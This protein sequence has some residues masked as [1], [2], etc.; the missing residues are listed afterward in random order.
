M[1][2]ILPMRGRIRSASAGA[3]YSTSNLVTTLFGSS[4][5]G[6][7][8]DA[9][10]AD[11]LYQ[12][13]A[14]WGLTAASS[15][16]D[17]VGIWMDVRN[18]GGD[19]FA[20]VMAAASDIQ[21]GY[22]ASAWTAGS[23]TVIDDDSAVKITYAGDFS[24]TLS[25]LSTVVTGGSLTFNDVY[26]VTVSVRV[27]SGAA[28]LLRGY[29]GTNYDTSNFTSTSYVQTT[30]Y[31][32][33]TPST[34]FLQVRGLGSGESIWVRL[35]SFKR[36]PGN[37]LVSSGTA[38]P[39]LAVSGADVSLSFDGT[40]DYM[41]ANLNS[42]LAQPWDRMSNLVQVSNT[43]GDHVFSSYFSFA[44]A[45]KQGT[46]PALIVDDGSSGPSSSSASIG[47]TAVVY[48][49]HDDTGSLLSVDGETDNTGTSGTNEPAWLVVGAD[50][51]VANNANVKVRRIVQRS[52]FSASERA[53][54]YGW[55]AAA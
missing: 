41:L 7:V 52:S 18:W 46:S 6:G 54:A 43:S 39:T 47:A 17:P 36:I 2:L 33:Q 14:G 42:T 21:S 28:A 55:A 1:S 5:D 45:L 22:A 11:T 31:F 29:N 15:N 53:L 13:N 38:R 40:D 34:P 12:V 16:G 35:D 20:N 8:W 51:S 25:N 23:N 9:D 26:A 32:A 10:Y 48:E 19:T 44:G 4:Q 49:R 24:T 37:H 50:G 27:S 30:F 3:D